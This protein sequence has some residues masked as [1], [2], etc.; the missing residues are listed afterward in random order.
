MTRRYRLPQMSTARQKEL[1]PTLSCRPAKPIGEG[2]EERTELR[3]TSPIG[4][5][6]PL[7]EPTEKVAAQ[8]AEIQ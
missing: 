5:F 8:G 7:P 6:R 3:R 1:G 4:G 2:P